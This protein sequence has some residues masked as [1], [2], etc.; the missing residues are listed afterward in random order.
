[1]NRNETI[2]TLW[3]TAEV[4][5]VIHAR[6]Q[7][8]RRYGASPQL[9]AELAR[10]K[11]RFVAVGGT[12]VP[13]HLRDLDNVVRLVTEIEAGRAVDVPS[14]I[15]SLHRQQEAERDAEHERRMQRIAADGQH[16]A[17]LMM[18]SSML[19]EGRRTRRVLRAPWRKH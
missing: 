5:E 15:A 8:R 16:Q 1:M 12:I 6:L 17:N 4:L 2:R 18:H 14:A 3:A 9:D 7:D 19:A 11:Q 10:L 13:E